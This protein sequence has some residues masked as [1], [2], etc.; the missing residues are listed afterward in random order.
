MLIPIIMF[1]ILFLSFFLLFLVFKATSLGRSEKRENSQ[2]ERGNIRRRLPRSTW[3]KK[4]PSPKLPTSL[5][6]F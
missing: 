1:C 5:T 3:N 6:Q 4:L 2:K